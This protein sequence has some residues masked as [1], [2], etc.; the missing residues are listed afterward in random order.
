[1]M[2]LP[3]KRSFKQGRQSEQLYNEDL[4]KTYESTRHIAER[5]PRGEVPELKYHG[6]L[7][8]NDRTNELKYCN[9]LKHKWENVFQ[10]K[11]Q[12]TDQ[13]LVELLPT[14]PVTGQLWIHN[15]VLYYFDGAQWI[16][17]KASPND[18]AQWEQSA[19]S[20]FKLISPLMAVGNT[21]DKLEDSDWYKHYY[22]DKVD[23]K[24]DRE[25]LS[26]KEKWSP[27]WKSP[28]MDPDK[29]ILPTHAMSQFLLPSVKY[30]KFFIDHDIHHDFEKVSSVTLQYPTRE[31]Y[32]TRE[33]AIHINYG[34][35]HSLKKRLIKVDKHNPKIEVSPYH[36]EYYGFRNGEYGGDFLRPSTTVDK[37]DYVISDNAIILNYKASQNYDYV[38]SITYNFGWLRDSGS[39]KII[40]SKNLKSGF[41]LKNLQQPV[42]VF[43]NGLNLESRFYHANQK[44]EIVLIEDEEFN[45]DLHKDVT[46]LSVPGHQHGFIHDINADGYG[47]IKLNDPVTSP[48]IFINGFLIHPI[49][50]NLIYKEDKIF[51]PG[52]KINMPWSV[53]ECHGDT[54]KTTLFRFA[55]LVK[56]RIIHATIQRGILDGT[57]GRSDLHES[58][59]HLTD[60][61]KLHLETKKEEPYKDPTKIIYPEEWRKKSKGGIILF[62]NGLLIGPDEVVIDEKEGY[63]YTKTGLSPEDQYVLLYDE[64]HRLYDT[65]NLLPALYTGYLDTAIVYRNGKILLDLP[66][67]M[68]FECDTLLPSDT[69]ANGEVRFFIPDKRDQKTGFYKIYDSYN[70]EWSD[71]T[72][73]MLKNVQIISTSYS[74][75]LSAVNFNVP[76]S[77]KDKIIIYAI[78]FVNTYNDVLKIGTPILDKNENDP[79]YNANK[80]IYRLF[81]NYIAG[82]GMLNLYINGIKQI[83]GLDYAEDYSG[84]IVRIFNKELL[85]TN[86]S[87]RYVIET[88]EKGQEYASETIILSQDCLISPN[89]YKIPDDNYTSFYP[90]RLTVYR[91]GVRLCDTDWSLLG[92]RSII[93]KNTNTPIVSK[94]ANNFPKETFL[95]ETDNSIFDVTHKQTE[96][97]VV[98]IR[99][100]F[101]RHETSFYHDAD[102]N[103]FY[104]EKNKI[105]PEILDTKDEILIY[106]N[107][108]FTGLSLRDNNNYHI[109]PY[110]NCIT[111]DN[112]KVATMLLND[113]MQNV[114][115]LFP[116]VYE[117]W[118]KRHGNMEYKH[119]KNKI[120]LVWR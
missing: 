92:D 8:R 13:M 30:D 50:N 79:T 11:L 1:M 51:V 112:S 64:S 41:L 117:D 38:L 89:V 91:N 26:I 69:L 4:H 24:D 97:I 12:I 82:F 25:T 71:I 46:M 101:N 86:P 57:E 77:P 2:S 14:N 5:P 34:K 58:V 68:E 63:I 36:T 9:M 20:D 28:Q 72:G 6:A 42:D 87:I 56:D 65:M 93:I 18:D 96:I 83:N 106:V 116:K 70:D 85:K 94:L 55:G 10:D 53:L 54:D 105:P 48:L 120:T 47:I 113:K 45:P 19:F 88:P 90:G 59:E 75:S 49:Y 43:I 98:E 67:I 84:T 100:E 29:K 3:Y 76:K 80:D 78:K 109:D 52:A 27:D 114:F 99:Q 118:K 104:I 31:L 102:T 61:D 74:C 115:D 15:Q 7:W 95:N 22:K 21:V 60:N 119:K 110:K 35:L 107:G 17:V 73:D 108:I 39:C 37:G 66:S 40:D 103:E 16:P 81:D 32:E 44:E 33:S 111:I 62:I 23:F